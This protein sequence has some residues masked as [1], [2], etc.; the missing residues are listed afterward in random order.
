MQKAHHPQVGAASGAIA[1][2]P[3]FLLASVLPIQAAASLSSKS[4]F[5]K[6]IPNLHDAG[7]AGQ[8]LFPGG[9]GRIAEAEGWQL[10]Y[11]KGTWQE[12]WTDWRAV[13]S[14]SCR[15]WRCPPRPDQV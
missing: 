1:L 3:F 10:E 12:C 8:W 7:R 5:M 15:M 6:I 13:R 14:T 9:F 2:F 4:A 11:E